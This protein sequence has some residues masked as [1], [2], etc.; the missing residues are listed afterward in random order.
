MPASR[1]SLTTSLVTA[2]GVMSR[3]ASS[4][5]SMSWT[6][7]TNGIPPRPSQPIGFTGT[8]SYPQRVSS[9][10]TIRLKS[11][12]SR[13]TPTRASRRW[14]RK[15]LA[16]GAMSM[17]ILHVEL[18][19]FGPPTLSGMNPLRRSLRLI[20]R[21]PVAAHLRGGGGVMFEMTRPIVL[22][23]TAMAG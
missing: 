7:G 11:R 9:D 13:D 8:T 15:L 2:G 4:G 19:Q 1:Q 22:V 10:R 18:L 21:P 23:A 14:A 3:A 12:E 6:R 17:V 5:G 16:A 20:D